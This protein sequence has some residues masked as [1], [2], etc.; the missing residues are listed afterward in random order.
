MTKLDKALKDFSENDKKDSKLVKAVKLGAGGIGAAGAGALLTSAFSPTY[1]GG[2]PMA[3]KILSKISDEFP[4]QRIGDV[5]GNAEY[6]LDNKLLKYIGTEKNDYGGKYMVFTTDPD[7][8]L[9]VD[10]ATGAIL[11]SAAFA[12]MKGAKKLYKNHKE[13]KAK[14]KN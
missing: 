9:A 12:A 4:Y 13:K 10:A 7:K 14:E 6:D 11:G 1:D 8:V 3:S 2:T 5:A